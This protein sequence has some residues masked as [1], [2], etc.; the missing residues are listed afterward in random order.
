METTFKE[1]IDNSL[2]GRLQRRGTNKNYFFRII[3]A[4]SEYYNNLRYLKKESDNTQSLIVFDADVIP[5]GE[6]RGQYNTI[7]STCKEDISNELFEP[8]SGRTRIRDINTA[9]ISVCSD[10]DVNKMF[11]S[12]LNKTLNIAFKLEQYTIP[13][14]KEN[15]ACDLISKFF[16]TIV[17]MHPELLQLGKNEV[18]KCIFYGKIKRNDIYFLLLL[19]FFDFDVFFIN[20]RSDQ[21]SMI[22]EQALDCSYVWKGTR[23]ENI[24][25]FKDKLLKK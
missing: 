16:V 5:D 8:K 12:A 18:P 1:A 4:D 14:Q 17:S 15:L 2:K 6:L 23:T 21:V 9:D 10:D 7:F 13:S 3:G 19:Y 22:V 11:R 25:T 20:P 24:E